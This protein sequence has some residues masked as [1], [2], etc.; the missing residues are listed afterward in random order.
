MEIIIEDHGVHGVYNMNQSIQDMI[1]EVKYL[2]LLRYHVILSFEK[3]IVQAVT[4]TPS[5]LYEMAST[6]EF[7][8]ID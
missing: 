1:E 7:N 2:Q 8:E 4:E 3:E 6:E 5:V